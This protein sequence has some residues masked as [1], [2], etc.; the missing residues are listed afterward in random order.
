MLKKGFGS[1][2]SVD[3]ECN[4]L[5]GLSCSSNNDSKC[6]CK[7]DL[8]MVGDPS[9]NRSCELK[10]GSRCERT[11]ALCPKKTGCSGDMNNNATCKCDPLCYASLDKTR[12]HKLKSLGQACT[13]DLEC[14]AANK[15]FSCLNHTCSCDKE[16]RVLSRVNYTLS[17]CLRNIEGNCYSK[18]PSPE[19]EFIYDICLAKVSNHYTVNPFENFEKLCSQNCNRWG[20]RVGRVYPSVLMTSFVSR[21]PFMIN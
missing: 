8:T 9:S 13:R 1:Q 19:Y 11:P 4:D 18:F 17:S 5:E 10:V 3:K 12:C 20:N 14:D 6:G 2:C 7:K 21:T 15:H 16:R